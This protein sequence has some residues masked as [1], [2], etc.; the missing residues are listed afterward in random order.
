MKIKFIRLPLGLLALAL[1]MPMAHA[2]QAYFSGWPEGTS[3][4][5]V[6]KRLADHFVS[7]PHQYGDTLHYSEVVTWY[8]ALQFA[9]VTQDTALRQQLI[10][11][12]Q[13]M[14][15]GGPEASRTPH[16]DHVDSLIFGALPLEVGIDTGDSRFVKYGLTWAD[17]EWKNPRPD[18]L[19]ADSRF[20]IDDMYM[21]TLLQVEAYRA[22]KDT[23]YL[24]RAAH[25]MATYLDKL[26]QPNGLF[27]HADNVPIY[28]GRGDGWVAAGMAELLSTLP[29]DHPDR[30]RIMK[31][32]RA[33]MAGLLRYQGKDGMWRQLLDD[34]AAWP[35]TSCSGMFTFALITGVRNG[36]L[37]PA[38]Y[39]PVARKAW[40]ALV[41]Y[42]DQNG[43]VTN[44]CEGTNKLND[45]AY[46]LARQRR[47]GDFHGQAPVLWAAAALLR[48]P[49]PTSISAEAPHPQE[50]GNNAYH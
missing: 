28:W 11:R 42:I 47:T 30:P 33:M 32:Y 16:V 43:D 12:F 23:R 7:S 21:I 44:V 49:L 37:E 8:G 38:I 35:E 19:S 4:A 48:Q 1:F 25:E 36:W 24:D 10:R 31:G 41:G 20:W 34:T 17:R 39:G 15:P 2:Q 6:G 14:M 22:T 29:A 27:Y 5:E 9:A 3:P 13:P 45:R 26:Q 46:Y 50:A 18:G 40:I